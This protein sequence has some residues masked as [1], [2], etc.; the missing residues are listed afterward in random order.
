MEAKFSPNI[1]A[2]IQNSREEAIRLG[3]D[4]IG[5]EHLLLAIISEGEGKTFQTIKLLNIDCLKLKKSIEDSIQGSDSKSSNLE[6][7]PLT[8]QAYKTLKLAYFE[9]KF[10]Q[11][12]IIG[13]EHLLLS[14]LKDENNVAS[15]VLNQYGITYSIWKNSSGVIGKKFL[16]YNFLFAFNA[17]IDIMQV[18][19]SKQNTV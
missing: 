19:S 11:I 2:V 13:T 8:K 6:K 7:P 14:I 5:C 4:Y 12:D 17:L 15:K 1:K 18:F 9:A 3:H 16:G 10:F